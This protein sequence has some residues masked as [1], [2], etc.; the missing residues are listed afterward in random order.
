MEKYT[1]LSQQERVAI[2]DGLKKLYP[3]GKIAGLIGRAP[4]TVSREI[5]R[6]SDNKGYYYY[7]QEAQERSQKKKS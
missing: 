2:F 6:N 1:Q 4:S 3:H 7:P 5:K